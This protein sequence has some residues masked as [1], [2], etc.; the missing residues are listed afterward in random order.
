M[1]TSD[2]QYRFSDM[3]KL[4]LKIKKELVYSSYLAVGI[5][6]PGLADAFRLVRCPIESEPEITTK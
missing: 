3:S 5:G 6:A 2:G 1:A 4:I